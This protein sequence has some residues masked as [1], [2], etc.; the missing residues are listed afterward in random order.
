MVPFHDGTLVG[1]QSEESGPDG[2][3]KEKPNGRISLTRRPNRTAQFRSTI[4]PTYYI[5]WVETIIN[6]WSNSAVWFL[7]NSAVWSIIWP[8]GFLFIWQSGF[9]HM[10]KFESE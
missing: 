4:V 9:G 6:Q 2:R 3:N 10:Y 1:K 8:S 5:Y 7:I